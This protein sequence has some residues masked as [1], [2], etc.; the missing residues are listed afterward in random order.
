MS[1]STI[2][3]NT[4][5]VMSAILFDLDGVLYECDRVIAGA[6][7]TIHWFNQNKIPHLFL[8]N[9]TSKSRSALVEKLA[10]FGIESKQQDF[11]TPP[12]A[13]TQWLH[14]NR[15]NDIA[16]FLPEETRAEFADFNLLPDESANIAAVVIGDLGEQWTFDT[17]N[18]IFR[19]LHNNPRC[20]LIA[21]G[22]TRY[23]RAPAGLQ[24]DVG[25]MIKAFEYATGTRAIVTGKPAAAFYQAA[26]SLL[27][28]QD[29]I[30][31]I[32]DDIHGDIE[33]A[34]KTGLKALLVRTG[35]FTEADLELGIT[36]DTILASIAELPAWWQANM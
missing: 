27:G 16:L 9:T 11:L 21:L 17:M 35:K 36:P 22:M 24:L 32:G 34:Q 3:H 2:I 29:D 7:A 30:V 18:T 5:E 8:T 1:G 25:P 14:T 20:K 26:I 12:V 15:L 10:G 33:A 23:W 19:I 6:A 31:M 4:G 28:P 13:A